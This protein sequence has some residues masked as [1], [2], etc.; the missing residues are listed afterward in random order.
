MQELEKQEQFEIEVLDRLKSGKFLDSL[1]FTGGTMLR[2]C[3]GLN[4]FSVDL[5]FWLYKKIDTENYFKKIKE[6]LSAFYTIRDAENKFYTMLFEIEGKDYPRTL[7]IEIRKKVERVKTDMSIAYS[8]FSNIQVLVRT[9]SLEEVMKSKIEAFLNRK[10]IRDVFDIEFL[11]KKG[12]PI[13][14]KKEDLI[15]LLEEI[16]NFSKKDYSVKLG[17]IIN[18]EWRKYYMKENFKILVMKLEEILAD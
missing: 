6:Y 3:Y 16:K 1:I 2:L 10:E 12:V 8:K 7:K 13:N 14:V 5:D 9:L 15:Q 17:S 18:A 11:L 4:R